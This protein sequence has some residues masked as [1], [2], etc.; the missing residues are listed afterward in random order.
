V[1][2]ASATAGDSA[3]PRPLAS[4]P[5]LP[6]AIAR[7]LAFAGLAGFGAL[8]WMVLLEPAA[9]DRALYALGAAAVAGLG[10]LAV[11][12]IREYRLRQAAAAGVA[13][14]ALALAL[15]GG[16]VADE[17]LR[18]DQWGALSSG[19]NRGIAAL[20]GVRVPYRGLDEWIR[21]VIPVGGT[22]L[23]T[24]AAI[25]AFWP[26]RNR[27]GFPGP[28]LTLLVALYAVPAVSLNF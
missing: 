8:H 11:G 21:I 23:V 22:V 19:I 13:L 26:R 7:G 15:L 3:V 25:L 5:T 27:I 6:V 28:A 18:P 20:P 12:R 2:A 4:D 17:L 16:G 10:L 24:A 1:S 14:V 9:P